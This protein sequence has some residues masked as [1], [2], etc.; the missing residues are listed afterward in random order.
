MR[1]NKYWQTPRPRQKHAHDV[2]ESK[3]SHHTT[4][5]KVTFS[6]HITSRCKGAT[7]TR[8]VASVTSGVVKELASVFSS[9]PPATRFT[10]TPLGPSSA[11]RFLTGSGQSDESLLG[12]RVIIVS[13]HRIVHQIRAN[14]DDLAI[15][16]LFHC[17]QYGLD[18]VD[19]ACPLTL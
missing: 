14:V 1:A 11:T 8:A 18:R 17:R 6:K 12:R 15:Q 2:A 7:S 10:R 19:S 16:L 13:H 9:N 5:P 4:L 3:A